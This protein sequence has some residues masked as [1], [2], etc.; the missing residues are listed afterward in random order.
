M[1]SIEFYRLNVAEEQFD[2]LG[3]C[4]TFSN[5][6]YENALNDIGICTFDINI[7][8][9]YSS[10][11]YLRRM[12]T[13]VVVKKNGTCVWFGPIATQSGNYSDVDGV[14]TVTA[15]SYLYF[16]KYRNTD[17]SQIY[18]QEE[19]TAIAW[20]LINT[21]QA[22]TNGELLITQGYLPTSQFRDR[23]YET[24]EIAEALTNLTNVIDGFDFSFE[25]T[26]DSNN[27]LSG[28]TF[29]CY[30]PNKGSLRDELGKLQVGVNVSSIVWSAVSELYNTVIVEGSGTGVPLIYTDSDSASQLAYTRLEGYEKAADVSEW[31]TLEKHGDKL[32]NDNKVEGYEFDLSVMPSSTMILSA[33]EV[34]DTVVCDIEIGKYLSLKDRQARISSMPVSVDEQGV[35]YLTLKVKIYG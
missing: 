20:D 33:L 21:T 29:N 7:L 3:E 1:Y 23:T 4:I 16:F 11:K 6:S 10:P 22:T 34:G 27:R 19:Q 32:L 28:V 31:D 9:E 35:D 26:F 18:Y 24:Y 17:K 2:F 30:Y 15:Y 25:A 13:I 8:D 14:V 12:S 5:L